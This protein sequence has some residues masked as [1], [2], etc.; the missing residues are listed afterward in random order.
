MLKFAN[1]PPVYTSASPRAVILH[2]LAHSQ[3][4]LPGMAVLPG[5]VFSSVLLCDTNPRMPMRQGVTGQISQG[6]MSVEVEGYTNCGC[7][8]AN[9]MEI[10]IELK[11]PI[12]WT[13]SGLSPWKPTYFMKLN[14]P[15]R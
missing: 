5:D 15:N 9:R 6:V 7:G 4:Q 1:T 11:F 14:V 3:H 2:P 12:S 10:S 13:P 8:S